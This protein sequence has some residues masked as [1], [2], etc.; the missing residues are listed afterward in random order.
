LEFGAS[1]DVGTRN[2]ESPK[3]VVIFGPLYNFP[4]LT[5]TRHADLRTWSGSRG[6]ES[7]NEVAKIE[8]ATTI[9]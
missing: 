3:K 2:L 9:R 4:A 5:P 8:T 7:A 6:T 1:L